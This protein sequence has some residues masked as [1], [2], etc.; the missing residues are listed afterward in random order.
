[1]N[2]TLVS[3]VSFTKKKKASMTQ[4]SDDIACRTKEVRHLITEYEET[5]ERPIYWEKRKGCRLGIS[6]VIGFEFAQSRTA[7]R[8]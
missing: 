7:S 3:T 1:M 6:V 4:E 8:H 5:E 2:M